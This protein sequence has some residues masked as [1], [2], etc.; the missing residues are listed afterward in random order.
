MNFKLGLNSE[1]S[2]VYIVML[3]QDEIS[4]NQVMINEIIMTQKQ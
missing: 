4:L 2:F 1:K 3:Y